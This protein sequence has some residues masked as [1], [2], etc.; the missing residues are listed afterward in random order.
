MRL[1]V[2]V[3][4]DDVVAVPADAAADV[5]QDLRQEHEHRADLVGDRLGRVIV[6][7]VERQT[8]CRVER[9]AEV[10]LV[11]ADGEAL[12]PDA[13]QLALDRVEIVRA[14]RLAP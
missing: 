12:E 3:E 8:A 9:V 14:G 1:E 10:V 2:V 5:Q 11:R 6:A 4:Q 7:G 13:E